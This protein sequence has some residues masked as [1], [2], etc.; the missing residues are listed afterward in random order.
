MLNVER[1]TK[2]PLYQNVMD[3]A[4]LG[5]RLG[6]SLGHDGSQQHFQLCLNRVQTVR[7]VQGCW[8][9]LPL[10]DFYNDSPRSA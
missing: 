6:Q 3:L 4:G 10:N 9:D 5:Q 8:I 1:P 2:G 7:P